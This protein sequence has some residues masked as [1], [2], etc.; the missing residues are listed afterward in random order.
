MKTRLLLVTLLTCLLPLAAHAEWKA[1]A[2][3]RNIT[4]KRF[5]LMAGYGGRVDPADGKLTDLWAKG[6][7]WKRRMENAQWSSASTWSVSIA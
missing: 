6:W 2:S 7:R 3:S 1:G 4:P 5:M